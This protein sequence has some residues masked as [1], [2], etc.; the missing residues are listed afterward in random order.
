M[1][2]LNSVGN[3]FGIITR[4]TK[5]A[6]TRP[7]PSNRHIGLGY[8]PSTVQVGVQTVSTDVA[9]KESTMPSSISAVAS[10]A[11]LTCVSSFNIDYPYS[12]HGGFVFQEELELP[13]SPFMHPLVVLSSSP[14]VFQVFHHQHIAPFQAVHNL[15][16]DVVVHP[17]LKPFPLATI[18]FKL[19][20]SGS[21]AFTLELCHK[22]LM[23]DSLCLNGFSVEF[24]CAGDCEGVYAEV[25][26]HDFAVCGDVDVNLFSEYKTEEQSSP[27]VSD[28]IALSNIPTEIFLVAFWNV[29]RELSSA[30]NC[31]QRQG[32]PVATYRGTARKVIADRHV[33][34]DFWFT[35]RLL[36]HFNSL[37]NSVAEKLALQ[38]KLFSKSIVAFTVQF[39]SISDVFSPS[40]IYAELYCIRVDLHSLQKNLVRRKFDFS[41]NH[42]LHTYIWRESMLK[43]LL[44]FLPSL[45]EGVSLEVSK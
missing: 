2:H 29:D 4:Q 43:M 10:I 20:F 28:E 26:T 45:K 38:T 6:F 14:Y 1:F 42:R 25:D 9:L 30:L 35:L 21:C 7:Q 24:G 23:S 22:P 41:C 15:P 39:H 19:S 40:N 17:S 18:R 8:I 37:F 33:L 16:R 44:Q 5:G 12:L 32:F 27:L 13:E 36:N 34:F 11:S 3:G 31:R